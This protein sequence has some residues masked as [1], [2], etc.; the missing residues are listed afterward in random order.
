MTD[1]YVYGQRLGHVGGV[2]LGEAERRLAELA[3]LLL[4]VRQPLHQTVLVDKFDATA[5]LAWIEQRLFWCTLATTYSTD[6]GG[7]I[8]GLEGVVGSG[9]SAVEAL[10]LE[11][12][13]G[14]LHGVGEGDGDPKENR[15]YPQGAY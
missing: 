2:E 8:L 4:R 7:R 5:A 1:E 12:W 13:G 6:A 9:S 3:V 11:T 14:I 15:P 10:E